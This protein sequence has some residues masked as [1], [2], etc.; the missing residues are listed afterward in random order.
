MN[1][2]SE[3]CASL[4]SMYIAPPSTLTQESKV[5]PVIV[6]SLPLIYIAPPAPF[7]EDASQAMKS[8]PLIVV[9]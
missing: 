5:A 8:E 1:S 4:P 7:S 6:V 2:D 9:P 3:I